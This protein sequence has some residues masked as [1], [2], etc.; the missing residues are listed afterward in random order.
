MVSVLITV[1]LVSLAMTLALGVIVARMLRDERRRSDARVAALS[2]MADVE[3]RHEAATV[4]K[5]QRDKPI[6]K[7]ERREAPIAK[8]ERRDAAIVKQESRATVDDFPLEIHQDVDLIGHVAPSGELFATRDQHSPWPR[9]LAVA[10]AVA[11]IVAVVGLAVRSRVPIEP[12]RDPA[13]GVQAVSPAPAGVLELLSLKHTR[14]ADALTITGLVQNPRD[15]APLSKIAATAFLFAADGTF[16]ASGRAPLDFIVLRPGDESPFVINVPVTAA[17]ARY[18]I[19]FRDEDGRI[20]G[21]VDRR[22]AASM[23]GSARGPR[24]ARPSTWSGRRELAEGQSHRAQ[25]SGGEPPPL[26]IV[27]MAKLR[28]ARPERS[29]GRAP[30]ALTRADAVMSVAR[31]SS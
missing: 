16:L 26:G 7:E 15:G 12:T 20:I 31:G 14:Q 22:G 17:V 28:R 6:A 13:V 3:A 30:Q 9:R 27:M 23:A 19:G 24:E 18:R 29:E 25:P 2:E 1:T 21:H 5:G 10:A 4:N 8:N 11:L